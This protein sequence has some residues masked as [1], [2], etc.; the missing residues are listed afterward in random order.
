MIN[1][2]AYYDTESVT[3]AKKVFTFK[4]T[5]DKKV[6]NEA[7]L[8]EISSQNFFKNESTKFGR[9]NLAIFF[10]FSFRLKD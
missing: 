7:F 8:P 1:T 6:C 2:L 9:K 10:P 3:A 5:F 4:S